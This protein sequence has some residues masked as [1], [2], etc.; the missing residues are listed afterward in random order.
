MKFIPIVIAALSALPL[1][2]VRPAHAAT[3]NVCS[4]WGSPDG[5]V[6]FGASACF[7]TGGVTPA[8]FAPINEA[9]PEIIGLDTVGSTVSSIPGT[10]AGSTATYTCNW[11]MVGGPSI[12]TNCA[13]FGALT[14]GQIG[15]ALEVDVTASNSA[16][17]ATATS[18]WVG[19]VE[20]SA[21][22][23]PVAYED[24]VAF[25]TPP[26]SISW[27][28]EPVNFLQNGHAIFPGCDIPPAAPLTTAG[29]V[30]YFDPING[31]TQTAGGTGA[32]L[33]H[34]F[35]DNS[36]IFNSVAGYSSS[37]LFGF[38]RTI[39]P[40]DTIYLEPG[41]G[42]NPAQ[43]IVTGS[44]AYSTS[45]GT[46]TGTTVFTW[47]MADPL[48][49]S[50]PV[51]VIPSAT[52]TA[53]AGIFLHSGQI[54][55]VFR[56][57]R[58]EP[59]LPDYVLNGYAGVN[60]ASTSTTAPDKNLVFE[61][62]SVNGQ[63]GHSND[64]A[65]S[66]PYP[67]VGGQSDGTVVTASPAIP[68]SGLQDGQPF[69]VTMNAGDTTVTFPSAPPVG[70]YVWSPGLYRDVNDF[71]PGAPLG[72][73]NGTKIISAVGNVATLGP[74]DP[75]ADAATGCPTTNYPGLGSNVP[76]CDPLVVL[77]GVTTGGCGGS[78]VAWNGATRN[79]TGKIQTTEQMRILPAGSFN[80]NDWGTGMFQGMDL[81]GGINA[82]GSQ[83][84]SE[85]NLAVGV[86]CISVKDG[87][88]RNLRDG[89]GAYAMTNSILYNNKVKW[90][91]GD[92][93]EIFSD[94]RTWAIH[95]YASDPTQIWDHQDAIQFANTSGGAASIQY[96]NAAVENELIQ[97]T[98]LTNYFPRSWQGINTTDNVWWGTYV[99]VN[100]VYANTNG[101]GI[102]GKYNVV[103]H[104]NMFGAALTAGFQ[105]KA[106]DGL[107][108]VSLIA[109]NVANGVS[110]DS[111]N[112]TACDPSLG[113]QDTVQTNISV[114]FAPGLTGANSSSYC[115]IGSTGATTINALAGQFVGLN[116]WNQIDW[117]TNQPVSALW[118]QYD[119]LP[120]P[121]SPNPGSGLWTN[122]SYFTCVQLSV[123]PF[124]CNT[125]GTPAGAINTRPNASFTAS[126]VAGI[127]GTVGA[128]SSLT[129]TGTIGDKWVVSGNTLCGNGFG[130]CGGQFIGQTFPGGV[131]TRSGAATSL[132]AYGSTAQ[133]TVTGSGF[134][135]PQGS[136]SLTV[137]GATAS[138]SS[139]TATSI[140]GTLNT[141][142]SPSIL[143]TLTGTGYGTTAGTV[144]IGGVTPS[145]TAWNATT[146]TG[147]MPSGAAFPTS[148]NTVINLSGGGTGTFGSAT[149][150]VAVTP[151]GGGSG[152]IATAGVTG[153]TSNSTP[154]TPGIIAA[155]TNLGAQQPIADQ[156]GLAWGSPPSIGAYD[157]PSSSTP[158]N[159]V[160]L[161]LRML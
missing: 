140:S 39:P 98:D 3:I 135:S 44:P 24:P 85:P 121:V 79:F 120:A 51:L 74:C 145:L 152:T 131:Y 141:T 93:Y 107:P 86:S 14:S 80:N 91:S 108:I 63:I 62:I 65:N 71:I 15:S 154:F 133:F 32:D 53:P 92:S 132:L 6:S 161:I 18:H 57:I 122:T 16:G 56:H 106:P 25:P 27:P 136:G 105:H 148:G 157:I 109:N 84:P 22:V 150:N 142:S 45:D 54:G 12:G 23:A 119:P 75:V 151:N 36:A 83:T 100:N 87:L 69:S 21:P 160:C 112:G 147:V 153:V 34:A 29:H 10:W 126:S 19:P 68:A 17:T 78:P 116:A 103:V 101:I 9:L 155:G 134:G 43:P 118:S 55:F 13:S 11:H 143:F 4:S 60:I 64:P 89:I 99:G 96:N 33:A 104:N 76:G 72:I 146:I 28:T 90:T 47:I 124:G 1:V 42:A 156:A 82:A 26:S 61:D 117:R 67:S 7:H 159:S 35:K 31:K 149:V 37:P 158:C 50:Y 8:V 2:S 30:W 138:I 73:P 127:T 38:G 111:L 95:N 52:A 77:N 125:A 110:R 139:W 88:F 59:S 81:Q 144:T 66:S 20:A 58:V 137:G 70:R 94:H 97:N 129:T 102:Q 41:N 48:A 130:I 128:I 115:A 123:T 5:D 46:A 113:D 40:G 114:P 49:A